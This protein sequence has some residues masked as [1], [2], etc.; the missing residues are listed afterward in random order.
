MDLDAI[1]SIEKGKILLYPSNPGQPQA[2]EAP[3]ATSAAPGQAATGQASGGTS[4]ARP[5]AFAGVD[6][7]AAK[8]SGKTPKASA[9][10]GQ[11][12]SGQATPGQA[13]EGPAAASSEAATTP[14]TASAT[15]P[16][17]TGLNVPALLTFRRM[18][19]KDRDDASA[20]KKFRAKLQAH[21]AKVGAVFVHYDGESGTWIMK[22]D[23]F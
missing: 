13:D 3:A 8:K 14:V 11:A 1:V 18:I 10:P 22:V 15:P 6:S 17:G 12:A 21:A 20:V 2:S 4:A 19:V 5:A 23:G 16:R 7:L 9:A